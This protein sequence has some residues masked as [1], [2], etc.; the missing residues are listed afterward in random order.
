MY[1]GLDY[2]RAASAREGYALIRYHHSFVQPVGSRR[3]QNFVAGFGCR[4]RG[5]NGGRI[6]EFIVA[7]GAECR[8]IDCRRT[9]SSLELLER[10]QSSRAVEKTGVA[11]M[12]TPQLV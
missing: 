9:N 4:H 11:C 7:D 2:G 10:H 6:G 5:L 12:T 3:K 1:V 8:Y